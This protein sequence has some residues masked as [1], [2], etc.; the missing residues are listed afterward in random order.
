MILCR[1]LVALFLFLPVN[2]SASTHL[3]LVGGG[4]RPESALRRFVEWSG[5]SASRILIIGWPSTIP[6][7]Y[8]W[9]LTSEFTALGVPAFFVSETPPES[10]AAKKRFI[11][12]L[13]SATGVFFTGGDQNRAMAAVDSL[14]LRVEFNRRFDA[15]VPFGGTSAG[16]ALMAG[17]MITGKAE[18]RIAAGL[19]LFPRAV[20][21][22]HFLKRNREA[23][24][25]AAMDSAGLPFGIGVDEDGALAI[26]D[27]TKAEVLGGTDVV[28][29][30]NRGG[31]I[32]RFRLRD[33]DRFDLLDWTPL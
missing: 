5:G 21:D 12:Q 30:E 3:L 25:L 19:G 17:S 31:Q 32:E 7:D 22:M 13:E 15:G 10:E 16:T 20:I 33:Q 14:G 1:W 6:G 27:S 23:R 29:Y 28:F 4:A 18:P 26:E 2:A 8:V 24:L 9:S 11:S